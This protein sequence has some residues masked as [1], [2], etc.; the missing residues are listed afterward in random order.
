VFELP[1]PL[2]IRVVLRGLLVLAAAEEM[3][4]L[5]IEPSMVAREVPVMRT[6]R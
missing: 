2:A 1:D 5:V 6:S 4:V 3:G